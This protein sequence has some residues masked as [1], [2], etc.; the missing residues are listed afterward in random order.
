MKQLYIFLTISLIVIFGCSGSKT[1]STPKLKPLT[2]HFTPPSTSSETND[3]T[4]GLISPIF[5][6]S[7]EESKH[8]PYKTYAKNMESDFIAMLTARGYK[9]KGPFENTEQMV[10]SD[11]KDIDLL[12]Q[13]VIDIQFTGN[14]LKQ[15][16]THDYST[17][18]DYPT[19]Y[20]D[21]DLS[22]NGTMNLSFSEPFTNTKILV[23]SL[24]TDPVTFKMKSF[25]SYD[26]ENIPLTDPL[27]WN[28]LSDNLTNVYGKT[29]QTV[30]SHLEPVELLQKKSESIE[31]KKNS[32]FVKE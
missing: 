7:F 5:V 18:R 29:L 26:A 15:G 23:Q 1:E 21:G 31:I 4:F 6:D 20:Y 17:G 24:K 22:M 32:G 10:Y 27:V 8:D 9:I 3:I 12:I 2:F 25:N 19:F 16:T 30:W 28:S 13:P 11:K 14:V